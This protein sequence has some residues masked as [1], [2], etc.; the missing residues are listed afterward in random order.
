MDK[1]DKASIA[2]LK[3]VWENEIGSSLTITD[4]AEDGSFKG[5]YHTV[6]GKT[7]KDQQFKVVGFFS[8]NAQCAHSFLISFIVNWGEV[9]ALTTWNGYVKFEGGKIILATTF[10]HTKSTKEVNFWDG[11]TTGSNVFVPKK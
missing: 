1:A 9:H 4:L 8:E 3:G 7:E 6:V 11:I 2:A 10:L 5:H